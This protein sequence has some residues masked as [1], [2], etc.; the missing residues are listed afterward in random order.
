[1]FQTLLKSEILVRQLVKAVSSSEQG[2]D[3]PE[4]I[5]EAS[6]RELKLILCCYILSVLPVTQDNMFS[7]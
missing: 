3:E 5:F 7:H 2:M 1:M 6:L 4:V